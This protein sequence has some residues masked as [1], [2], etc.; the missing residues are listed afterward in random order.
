[1]AANEQQPPSTPLPARKGGRG[2]LLII[3]AVVVIL[4]GGGG[5]AAYFVMR[6]PPAARDQHEAPA[7][8]HAD[9]GIVSFEPFVV[10]LADPGAA[11]YLR[12]SI[13]L[14]VEKLEEA[15]R[16]Q[17]SDVLLMR[18]RSG[19]LEL[20]SNQTSERIVTPEGKT[21]LKEAIATS[22]TA[23]VKPAKV[24]DVLFSD[25]VVQF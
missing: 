1:M 19:I 2:K 20:L 7:P 3:L 17:K 12:I 8:S 16:I 14:I 13:R 18:L 21:A 6:Q 5:A 9:D 25:L 4:L 10:N 23:V 11:R 24:S 22:A 15:E